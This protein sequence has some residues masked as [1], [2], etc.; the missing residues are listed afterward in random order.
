MF[1]DLNTIKLDYNDLRS[2]KAGRIL[3]LSRPYRSVQIVVKQ[4]MRYPTSRLLE[5]L[6]EVTAQ[7]DNSELRAV[8]VLPLLTFPSLAD[9]ST[10]LQATT[11]FTDLGC[12]EVDTKPGPTGTLRIVLLHPDLIKVW[13]YFCSLPPSH[14][15]ITH[16]NTLPPARSGI[17]YHS[18][19]PY[20]VAAK[21]ESC[22]RERRRNAWTMTGH[23]GGE[24]CWGKLAHS[25][26]ELEQITMALLEGL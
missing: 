20:R 2:S 23:S 12:F 7:N 15:E 13:Q 9:I 18:R 17:E 26:E 4:R 16:Y 5:L 10:G 11:R 6:R 1:Y 25:P 19:F 24:A 3:L 8:T 22:Y 14:P 21:L